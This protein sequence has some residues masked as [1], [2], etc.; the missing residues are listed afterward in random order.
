MTVISFT[1]TMTFY[2]IPHDFFVFILGDE[3]ADTG[4]YIQ[5]ICPLLFSR[6]IFNVVAPSISYTLQNHYL[7]IW[8]I[9]Y[10]LALA[11]LFWFIYE[12]TVENVLLLYAI[13]GAI[14]Y[15]ILGCVS[16]MALKNH[17]KN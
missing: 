2:I 5:L 12:L 17:I 4:K 16:F 10:L 3:W 13:F 6:F 1:L 11:I 9:I 7:L 8:Q 15:A 14:M